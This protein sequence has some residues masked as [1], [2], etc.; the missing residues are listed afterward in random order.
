MQLKI[1]SP[2]N[3]DGL[4]VPP[5]EIIFM[6]DKDAFALIASGAAEAHGRRSSSLYAQMLRERAERQVMGGNVHV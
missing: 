3:V 2:V 4:P 6:P 1:I 5:G